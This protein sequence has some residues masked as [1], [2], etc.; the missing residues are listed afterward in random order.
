MT[1]QRIVV[2]WESGVGETY[3]YGSKIDFLKE[4]SVDFKNDR[5]PS[6]TKIHTWRSKGNYQEDRSSVQLPL[7]EKNKKYV[8]K[9]DAI[10]YPEQSVYVQ[11]IFFNRF[12]D[13]V[14]RVIAKNEEQKFL[15][16]E[17]AYYYE[18]SL[19]NVGMTHLKF[20]SISISEIDF[21]SKITYEEGGLLLSNHISADENSTTLNIVFREPEKGFVS[22]LPSITQQ[23]LGDSIEIGTIRQLS[24]IYVSPKSR[25]IIEEWL[26]EIYLQYNIENINWIGHGPVSNQ[27]AQ[28]YAAK[29]DFKSK[30]F[31]S[32]TYENENVRAQQRVMV[33]EELGTISEVQ[34]S[35]VMD[36]DY[37]KVLVDWVN[38]LTSKQS[39]GGLN[40]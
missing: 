20:Y 37:D 21:H 23:K 28:V 16:P 14:D 10:S 33:Y 15:Y 18:I 25:E 38:H 29:N 8:V 32:E 12:H 2:Y 35:D 24:D 11:I 30:L 27:A 31:I 36:M 9:L 7:L 3:L 13:I 39:N 6:G 1:N 22:F 26:N 17:A 40:E 19:L 5:F 4:G 34:I